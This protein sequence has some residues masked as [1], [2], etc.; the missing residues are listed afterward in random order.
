[1]RI[2]SNKLSDL[3]SFYRSELRD[4]YEPS[5]INHLI[6]ICFG[7]YLNFTPADLLTRSNEN[8]NQSDIIKL[9]DCCLDLKKN[10]PVQYILKE[11]IF[12]NLR[13]KVT[14]AVLIPRPETEEL[15]ELIIKENKQEDGNLSVLDIGTGSG[16]IAI[17]LK[18]N[19]PEADVFAIDISREALQV[20]QTNAQSNQ[21][22]VIFNEIDIL[23]R[24][25]EMMLDTYDIIVSNPPYIAKTEAKEM[26]SRVK[27]HE[28]ELALFVPD[29]DPLRFYSR[30]I[31]LCK[32]HLNPSGKL[33][34][35]LN[36]V[37]AEKIKY[38]AMESMMFETA[39]ILKDLSG[40]YRFL[41]AVKYE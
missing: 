37:Y 41:N 10:I 7:H 14:P 35:E 28:P 16:C 13:F 20:A 33:Y 32:T 1:M 31:E 22:T 27:D 15:V 12:Y 34:F 40:N 30:I 9:Y 36:P 24:N 8:I 5:E 17:S 11:T 21:C 26:H 25:A 19:L 6:N 29:E 38:L 18:N 23:D 39:E 4:I 3:I 2:A